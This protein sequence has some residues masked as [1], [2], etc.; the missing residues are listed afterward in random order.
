MPVLK[1]SEPHSTVAWDFRRGTA[2]G[3]AE[4][5]FLHGPPNG[6]TYRDVENASEDAG[7][8]VGYSTWRRWAEDLGWNNLPIVIVIQTPEANRNGE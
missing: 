2:R 4:L 6:G 1:V 8:K 5:Y 7:H 3:C